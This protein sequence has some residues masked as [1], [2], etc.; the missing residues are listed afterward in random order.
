MREERNIKK[1]A[2]FIMRDA[3]RKNNKAKPVF[4]MTC[5]GNHVM[6]SLG[7]WTFGPIY[8]SQVGQNDP[9]FHMPC[10]DFPRH[11][12]LWNHFGGSVLN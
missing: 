2:F 1:V 6:I 7:M 10:N 3:K 12:E 4:L 11:V 5:L 8:K 9:T